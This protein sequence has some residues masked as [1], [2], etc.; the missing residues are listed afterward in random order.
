MDDALY[1]IQPGSTGAC[2]VA[3]K[4]YPMTYLE[5]VFRYGAAPGE[6]EL[7]AVDGMR[8]VYGIQRV[9]FNSQARTVRVRFDAS[10]LKADAVSRLFRQAGVDVREQ[11]AL[12]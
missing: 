6:T 9:D 5:V 10:R 12:A 11:V 3:G 2:I 4:D 7:R 8:E 1:W